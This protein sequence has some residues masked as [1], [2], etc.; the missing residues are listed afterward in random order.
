MKKLIKLLVFFTAALVLFACQQHKTNY[1]VIVSLDAFRWDLPDMY[2]MPFIDSM[3]SVGVKARMEPSFPAS[4]FPN[5]YTLATGLVPD[6]NGIVN[7]TFWNPKTNH[8]YAI[9]D[10]EARFSPDYYLGEPVWATAQ[11]QGEKAG[12]I[13]WVGSD[14]PVGGVY[15]TYYR[16]WNEDPHW[17]FPQRVDEAVRLLSLPKEERPRLVMVYFDEPDHTEHVYGPCSEEASAITTH[18]DSLV[19]S[20]YLRLKALPEVGD[21]LNFIVTGDHGMTDISP[22]RFLCIKD[23]VPERWIIRASG[24]TPTSLWAAPGCADSLYNALQGIEHISVWRHGEVPEHLNYGTSDR[25]GEVI[26]SPDLGWQFNW[27]PSRSKGAHGFDCQEEDMLVAFRAMGPDFKKNYEA[28]FTDGEPS[29]F[30]NIDIY[31]L[32]CHLLGVKPAP[33]DGKLSRIQKILK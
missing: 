14:I 27:Q 3:A 19:H 16:N 11:R 28:P 2:N 23:Y 15:P 5:H 31:P 29:A 10:Q 18:M 7:N 21:K 17:D 22:D 26:V 25:L 32:L 30:K 4:T 33:V 9:S 20:L 13:Y 8:S 12:V 1:T 24:N 6:H